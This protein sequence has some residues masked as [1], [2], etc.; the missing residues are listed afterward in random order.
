[1]LR[2]AMM[3]HTSCKPN[4]VEEFGGKKVSELSSFLL[5]SAVLVLASLWLVGCGIHPM[6]STLATLTQVHLFESDSIILA[7][8]TD[9]VLSPSGERVIVFSRAGSAFVFDVRTGVAIAR[10]I[11]ESQL[12]DSLA[13]KAHDEHFAF[14]LPGRHSNLPFGAKQIEGAKH[15]EFHTGRFINDSLIILL[16]VIHAP[17]YDTSDF[18][19]TSNKMMFIDYPQ[20]CIVEW[21]LSSKSFQVR[22][23]INR[24]SE[25]F[26][27][28]TALSLDKDGTLLTD[29]MTSPRGISQKSDSAWLIDRWERSGSFIR[30]EVNAPTDIPSKKDTHS[31]IFLAVADSNCKY[32]AFQRWPY[33]YDITKAATF[34]L[35]A[36]PCPELPFLTQQVTF[37]S[38]PPSH[39]FYVYDLQP[40]TNGCSIISIVVPDPAHPLN[41]WLIQ[42]YNSN[43]DLVKQAS[44]PEK[45]LD[46]QLSFLTYSYAHDTYLS[47]FLDAT[48]GWTLK[49]SKLE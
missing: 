36:L 29:V 24:G 2:L 40:V 22:P 45:G 3:L 5:N 44:N 21:S 31:K 27:Q 19:H 33:F 47:F 4:L 42:Q 12:S 46:G 18:F 23:L 20:A 11:P 48:K 28:G 13:T 9:A 35:L 37:S 6:S 16:S 1:V 7:G 10:F 26:P 43:G 49:T 32:L 38:L 41:T 30:H 25:V 39:P 8:I 14:I 15:G 34:P 17:A